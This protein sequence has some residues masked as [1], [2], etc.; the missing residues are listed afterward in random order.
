LGGLAPLAVVAW[1]ITSAGG[2][3]DGRPVTS[4]HEWMPSLGVAIALRVGA[5]SLL[6]IVLLSG[7]G[8]LVFAYGP[9]YFSGADKGG[10]VA[11]LLTL[12]AG[13][14]L[15]VVVADNLLLL[16]VCWEL[17]SVTSYLLIGIDDDEAEPRA[18]ALHALLVTASGGLAMLGG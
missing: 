18:A 5:F 1:A 14:M 15:G 4:S 9:G 13:A 7:S 16:Y 8:A 2:I 10:R 12:F 6:M 17:T 3:L 11:G